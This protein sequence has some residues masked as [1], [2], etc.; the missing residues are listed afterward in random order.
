MYVVEELCYQVMNMMI[1]DDH[2]DD[3]DDDSDDDDDDDDDD[4]NDDNNINSNDY[5]V[6][7]IF[8]FLNS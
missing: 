5:I 1:D 7:H 6:L 2:D 3:S 4:D 8:L